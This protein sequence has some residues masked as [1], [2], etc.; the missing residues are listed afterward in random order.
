MLSILLLMT[1][2][3]ALHQYLAPQLKCILEV[4]V[5]IKAESCE[6]FTIF[7]IMETLKLSPASE[8][9]ILHF[10][11]VASTLYPIFI[12]IRLVLGNYL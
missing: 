11:L 12:S 4:G 6:H 9:L 8:L 1:S 7:L 3:S 5:R 2:D 10:L